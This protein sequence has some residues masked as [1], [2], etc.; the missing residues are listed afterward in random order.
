MVT[1]PHHFISLQYASPKYLEQDSQL[2]ILQN[3][4]PNVSQTLENFLPTPAQSTYMEL[5]TCQFKLKLKKKFSSSVAVATFQVVNSHMVSVVI[6]LNSGNTKYCYP[7]RGS[8]PGMG[9]KG[10]R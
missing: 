2:I 3:E 10:G 9:N 5:L 6:V 8:I 7:Q 1:I 4:W